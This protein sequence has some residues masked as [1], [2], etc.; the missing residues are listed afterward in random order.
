MPVEK[1]HLTREK[2]YSYLDL[3][4]RPTLVIYMSNVYDIHRVNFQITYTYNSSWLLFKPIILVGFFMFIF[5][6][7]IFYFRLDLTTSK[8]EREKQE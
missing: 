5:V 8:R 2:S 6:V 3:F 7:L 1:F 4:G